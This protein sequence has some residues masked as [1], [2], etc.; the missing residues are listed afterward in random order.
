MRAAADK[1]RHVGLIVFKRDPSGSTLWLNADF[2]TLMITPIRIEQYL[3]GFLCGAQVLVIK[4]SGAKAVTYY[5]TIS[6][7]PLT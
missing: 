7:P 4:S 5:N 6:E 2:R 1:H 3:M